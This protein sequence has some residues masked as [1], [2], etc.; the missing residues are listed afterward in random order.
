MRQWQDMFAW[1]SLSGTLMSQP[2]GTL[3]Q[4]EYHRPA[5]MEHLLLPV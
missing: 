3:A 4:V 1:L 2:R 5:G